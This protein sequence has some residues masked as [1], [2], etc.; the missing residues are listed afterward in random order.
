M[1][2]QTL[3]GEPYLSFR[4][5]LRG[6]LSANV[7]PDAAEWERNREFPKHLLKTFADEGYLGLSLPKEVGGRGKDLWHEVILAEELA[8]TG[9][10]GWA[11]SILVHTNMVAPLIDSLATDKQKERFL[12]PALRGDFY[13][14]LAAT[15]PARGSDLVSAETRAIKQGQS[16]IL[17]GEKT[18]I[19]NGSVA[20]HIVTLAK[21]ETSGEVWSL[22][23]LVVP[24]DAE[25]V[26]RKRLVTSGL[27]SGDTAA[28]SLHECVVPVENLL[29]D[30]KRGFLYLLKGLQRERLMCAIALNSLALN[31]WE[32]TLIF[33][34]KRERFGANLSQKQVI[35]HRMA[36]SRSAI[37][38]S[39]QFAYNTLAAFAQGENVDQ[40][41]LMLKIFTYETGQ[42][43][44]QECL[45]LHGGEGFLQD[46]WI[47]HISRDSQAFTIA[48]G[49]SEIMRDLL[50]GMLKM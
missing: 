42:K 32:R 3:L 6:F 31:V 14:A 4:S 36:E 1:Q 17:Q 37:E 45:H 41:I 33:L 16:F 18:Y 35:R 15:E 50:A 34:Q 10:L 8:L 7:E 28:I 39:R 40:E 38:A 13:L 19:T 47:A 2:P 11:L 43:V 26:A 5:S 20:D 46:H 48:A 21:T 12:K 24:G 49:T 30:S 25:G 44:I 9:A 23:L 22:G 27:R 29:G